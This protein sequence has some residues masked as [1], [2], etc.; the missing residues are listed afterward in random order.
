[1]SKDKNK[2]KK[3]SII[4]DAK[5]LTSR[6]YFSIVAALLSSFLKWNSN[7]CICFGSKI[8]FIKHSPCVR[9]WYYYFTKYLRIIHKLQI[10]TEFYTT[11]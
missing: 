6:I 5:N 2:E 8:L 7:S 4:N 10:N 3:H 9:F 11:A 1:M